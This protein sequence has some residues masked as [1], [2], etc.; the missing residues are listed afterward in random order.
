MDHNLLFATNSNPDLVAALCEL[1]GLHPA[2]Y[3]L[4]RFAD[5][6]IS[7][8]L[9]EPVALKVA[10]VLGSDYPP[11]DNL[12]ELLTLINTLHI[13]GVARIVAVIPYMGYGKSDRLDRPNISVNAR[14]V[15]QTLELAGAD[16]FITL[17]LHSQLINRYF[18]VP[19]QD[20]SAMPLF[21]EKLTAAGLG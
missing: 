2:K 11:T 18:R 19:H 4:G 9:D 8:H 12:I 10:F 16:Q 7:L 13:N 14:L 6:E 5:G 1:T 15:I 21:A 20:L 3:R 17:N